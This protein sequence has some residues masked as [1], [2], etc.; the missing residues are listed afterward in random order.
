MT[1]R[2]L[3]GRIVR[4]GIAGVVGTGIYFAALLLLVELARTPPVPASFLATGIVAVASYLINRMFVFDTNRSHTSAFFRF[5]AAS[6]W[7]AV[8]N[9]GLMRLAIGI[10]G[11]PYLAGAVLTTAVVPPMNFAVNYLWA[12]RSTR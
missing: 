9:A 11:W 4:Y 2:A 12:F 5:V 10:L 6:V 1:N 7:S 8:V 3:L